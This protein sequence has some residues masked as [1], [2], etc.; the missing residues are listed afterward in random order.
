LRALILRPPDEPAPA[1]AAVS[2]RAALESAAEQIGGALDVEVTAVGESPLPAWQVQQICAAVELALQNVVQHAEARHAWVF[3][4]DEDTEVVVTVRD[5]GRGFVYD[6]A[7]LRAGGKYGLLRSI[8]G[9]V[10]ELGGTT[11]IDTAPGKGT[12]LELRLPR[13]KVRT[14]ASVP[15]GG[16]GAVERRTRD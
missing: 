7:Q 5:D 15:E 10:T 9:R 8:R 13:D 11:R 3:I 1:D 6:E 4:D 2:L 16:H 14:N 12:E